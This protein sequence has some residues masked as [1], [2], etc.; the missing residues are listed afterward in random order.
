MDDRICY[1]LRVLS[2]AAGTSRE[3]LQPEVIPFLHGIPRAIFQQ[4]N[5]RPHVAKTVRDFCSAQHM[6]LLPLPAFSLDMSPIEHV[7][8]LVG[9]RLARDPLQKTNF[10]FAYKQYGILFHKQ[11]F[12][13]C[14]TLCYVV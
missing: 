2:I 3:R 1:E 5:A 11:A 10:C 13:F 7:W 4:D 14:L 6:Q 9:R 8:Y 12:K